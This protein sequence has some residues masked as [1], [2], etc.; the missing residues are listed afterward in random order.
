M[1]HLPAPAVT[2]AEDSPLLRLQRPQLPPGI[3]TAHGYYSFVP[4]TTGNTAGG[5][6]GH[7]S[8]PVSQP[9]VHASPLSRLPCA[10]PRRTGPSPQPAHCNRHPPGLASLL[11]WTGPWGV[12]VIYSVHPLVLLRRWTS[13]SWLPSGTASLEGALSVSSINS[14][15]LTTPSAVSPTPDPP[16]PN[17][18]P[19]EVLERL[20]IHLSFA[21]LQTVVQLLGLGD[22][23]RVTAPLIPRLIS[24][25][26]DSMRHTSPDGNDEVDR[27]LPNLDLASLHLTTKIPAVSSAPPPPL[28]PELPT[29]PAKA[30][31]YASTPA[32]LPQYIISHHLLVPYPPLI[33]QCLTQGPRLKASLAVLSAQQPKPQSPQAP[34]AAYVV[35]LATRLVFSRNVQKLTH[36]YCSAFQAGFPSVAVAEKALVYARA[37]GWTGDSSIPKPPLPLPSLYGPNALNSPLSAGPLQWYVVSRGVHPGIYSSGL[38]CHLNVATVKSKQFVQGQLRTVSV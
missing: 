22:L 1:T 20:T 4:Y 30:P 24:T 15:K 5:P 25:A 10:G 19:P 34:G 28:S 8:P 36:G 11:R 18:L 27:T 29:T 38:E 33:G 13:P 23:A 3:S 6:P 7:A 9:A 35:L 21:E 14:L 31:L 37:Q 16:N 32:L 17:P 26:Q 2:G 12:N